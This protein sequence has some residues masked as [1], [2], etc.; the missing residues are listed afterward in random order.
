[1]LDLRAAIQVSA[2]ATTT[3]HR[4]EQGSVF[5]KWRDFCGTFGH[6]AALSTITAQEDK[7]CYILIFGNRYRQRKGPSGNPVKADTVSKACSQVGQGI[8]HLGGLNP[9]KA[10]HG[11]DANHPLLQ[12]FIEALRRDDEPSSRA[13]PINISIIEAM[14]KAL[15]FEDPVWGTLNRHTYLLSVVAYYWLMRPAEYCQSREKN[16][17]SQA[18]RFQDVQLTFGQG[19]ST[20][21]YLAPLAPL[22]DVNGA[23]RTSSAALTFTDQKN[24]VRGETISQRA[25]NHPELCPAKAL[26]H[27]CRHL[28]KHKAA[29]DTP[30]YMHYNSHPDH[31]KW[32]AVK[33]EF[34]TNALRHAAALLEPTTG[35]S[36]TLA[37]ARGIRP[38]AATALL[39]AGVDSDHIGL[40]G[41]WKSDAMFRYLR[42]QAN[43]QHMSQRMLDHGRYTFAP[44]A[45][46]RLDA[47]PL[48]VPALYRDLL[49]HA[50][51]YDS[52][53][54]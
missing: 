37:S 23:L 54:E 42:I 22:N 17:R 48:Q 32:Y 7:L 10:T 36:A 5:A 18:F 39:C 11:Q 51:L 6:D 40:L 53:D 14:P 33:S 29:P 35:I 1:M 19:R 13:Y 26:F 38:G 49:Q 4:N 41:R 34:I 45:Y 52:D 27:L 31:R 28:R 46:Q 2:T 15:D 8:A 43:N 3:K 44:G 25:N 47:L 21:T 24:A 12:D 50:E 30:L 20:K 9:C 16:T